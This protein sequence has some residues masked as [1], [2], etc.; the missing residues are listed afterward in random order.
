MFNKANEIPPSKQSQF[1]PANRKVTEYNAFEK[2]NPFEANLTPKKKKFREPRTDKTVDN[3]RSE[4]HSKGS[5][6]EIVNERPSRRGMYEVSRSPER[7]QL[8]EKLKARRE[9]RKTQRNMRK[10]STGLQT[11]LPSALTTKMVMRSP[12]NEMRAK[13]VVDAMSTSM[14]S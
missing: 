2:F 4:P 7:D 5:L 3:R 11:E 9:A 6:L 10:F 12:Q 14:R 8:I 1:R 13:L